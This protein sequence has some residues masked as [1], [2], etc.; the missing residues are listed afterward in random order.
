MGGRQVSLD[1]FSLQCVQMY[2]SSLLM[3]C[4]TVMLSSTE[5]VRMTHLMVSVY[6]CVCVCVCVRACALTRSVVREMQS[7]LAEISPSVLG[8][9]T[10]AEKET[11]EFLKK[12][13]LSEEDRSQIL[14]LSD[15]DQDGQLTVS[16]FILAVHYIKAKLQGLPLP[17]EVPQ[18]L[19][20][21]VKPG[22]ILP[23]A[24]DE[25]IAKCKL[26]FMDHRQLVN[27]NGMLAGLWES[28]TVFRM[29]EVFLQAPLNWSCGQCLYLL[30]L[31]Q[32]F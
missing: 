17:D 21:K 18:G 9:C 2:R 4:H 8:V 16:E 30:Q 23:P 12:T 31:F 22:P 11:K 3:N 10:T 6:V 28:V 5:S 27:E 32:G 13:L 14:Q 24:S 15:M 20:K 29:T 25:H 19:K 7:I 1:V 26:A